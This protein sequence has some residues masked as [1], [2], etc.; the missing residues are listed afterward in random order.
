[1]LFPLN[2]RVSTYKRRRREL[3]ADEQGF[4]MGQNAVMY[5]LRCPYEQ[6]IFFL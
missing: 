3:V 5:K 4:Y 6:I 2:I 1:M